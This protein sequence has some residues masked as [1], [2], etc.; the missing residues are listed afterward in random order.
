MLEQLAEREAEK[1]YQKVLEQALA[2][3]VACLRMMF[4][5][6]W[7]PRKAQPINVAMPPIRSSEDALDAIAAISIALGEGHL[8]PD[9]ITA[10]SSVIGRSIQVIELQDLERRIA[11]LEEA[12]DTQNEKKNSAPS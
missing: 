10:L 8:T 2:G 9:E 7:P 1:V 12:R 5:R 4:D 3:D 11:A 6:Y